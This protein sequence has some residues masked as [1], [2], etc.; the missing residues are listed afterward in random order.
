MLVTLESQL[1]GVAQPF[2][3]GQARNKIRKEEKEERRRRRRGEEGEEG[4]EK[5]GGERPRRTR[6]WHIGITTH[7]RPR[8]IKVEKRGRR[9]REKKR[10]RRRGEGGKRGRRRGEGG[11]RTYV[12]TSGVPGFL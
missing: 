2:T 9:R 1:T 10:G 5:E 4:G 12:Q 3:G 11:S 8:E 7:G 6:C